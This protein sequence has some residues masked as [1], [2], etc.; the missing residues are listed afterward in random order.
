MRGLP[1][2]AASAPGAALRC[3]SLRHIQALPEG[4]SG[5][6]KYQRQVQA[7]RKLCI[8][9]GVYERPAQRRRGSVGALGGLG[10]F[11]ESRLVRESEDIEAHVAAACGTSFPSH[12]ERGGYVPSADLI[13]AANQCAALGKRAKGWRDRRA[14]AFR[15]IAHNLESLEAEL[16][17]FVAIPPT[18][19][20]IAGNVQ[21][22]LLFCMVDAMEW[23]DSE[24]PIRMLTGMPVLGSISDTGLYRPVTPDCNAADFRV[25]FDAVMATNSA[26]L[27]EVCSLVTHRAHRASTPSQRWVLQELERVTMGEVREGMLGPPMT[28]AQ[29]VGK[30]GDS[31]RPLPRFAVPKN[32]GEPDE[33]VRAIDDGKLSGSNFATLMPETIA[34]PTFELPAHIAAIMAEARRAAGL[35]PLE[36]EIGL[37]DL[38][39][40][41]RRV[42]TSQPQYTTVA[43]WSA[44]HKQV[45]FSEVYGHPFGLL[46]SVVNFHRVPTLLCAVARRVFAV[47]VDHFFDDYICVEPAVG[48]G[49]AQYA[50][51]VVHDAVRFGLAP[52][53]RKEHASA[54]VELG[55][56]CDMSRAASEGVVVF[57]PTEKR[58]RSV[59]A[60]LKRA[61]V[62]NHLSPSDASSLFGKLGF[63]L[64]AA[65]GKVGRAATQPLIQR[66]HRDRAPY[67]FSDGLQR[68][69]DF[70][71]KLLPSLPPM[72]VPIAP[73]ALAPGHGMGAAYVYSDASY[74]RD[75]TNGLGIA[76]IDPVSGERLY[77]AGVCPQWLFDSFKPDR[78]TYIAQL[79]ALATVLV[80]TTFGARLRGRKVYHFCDNTVALSAALHGYANQPDLADASNALHCAA[81]GL[82][83]DLW[84]EWVASKANLADVPSRPTHDQGVLGRLGMREV[85][86]VFPTREEWLDPSLL[87][88]REHAMPE[89][90]G[91]EVAGP[92][93]SKRRRAKG[94]TTGDECAAKKRRIHGADGPN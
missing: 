54:N 79:E 65:Y 68:M 32:A 37:D 14:Q 24:L 85:R 25:R 84:L 61:R 27:E 64:S 73:S 86:M 87:L 40:A 22:A 39:A 50:L 67:V 38:F 42:P 90:V 36:L 23:P 9:T 1:L 66:C 15:A 81:C 5:L 49:S 72:E 3:S 18:V 48:Q 52:K 53:K 80:Y 62:Q 88:R 60:T 20:A 55:V 6:G 69:H 77:A 7:L 31:G 34:P 58:V 47:P 13:A 56:F 33:T 8:Y 45:M 35:P 2:P 70:L 11:K 19:A 63:T 51:R 44:A 30:Y 91:G 89:Y 4:W 83:I 92:S 78:K 16:R 76:L 74:E 12:V 75:G 71:E 41:Y 29:F 57:Q 17:S 21:V 26:W 28:R 82:R 93:R 43:F 10:G 46:A 59:L 94:R